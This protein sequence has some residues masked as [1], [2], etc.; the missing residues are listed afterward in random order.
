MWR[1]TF[2]RTSTKVLLYLFQNS[3][4]REV[5]TAKKQLEEAQHDKVRPSPSPSEICGYMSG[6]E[7]RAGALA[8]GVC[9]GH[10]SPR[11]SAAESFTEAL[12]EHGSEF[13]SFLIHSKAETFP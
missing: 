8:T 12:H 6:A 10:A 4:L 11:Q 7:F 13:Q 1:G 3:L 2:S 9:G 5:E